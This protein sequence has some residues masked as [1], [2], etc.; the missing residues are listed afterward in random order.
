MKRRY[1]GPMGAIG[2]LYVLN[3]FLLAPLTGSR[4][5]AWHFA[6]FL[7]GALM[8]CLLNGLLELMGQQ[9]LRRTWVISAFSLG[10]G[11]FWEVITPL[12][13]PRSVGDPWD[14]LSVWL[15]AMAMLA[16]WR[17]AKQ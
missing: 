15:G 12:Y 3:R 16:V 17:L 14:I 9:P 2:T 8:M 6:D 13:L 1:L 10:C 5:L 7:A 11:L 4:L